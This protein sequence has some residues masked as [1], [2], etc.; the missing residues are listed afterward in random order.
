MLFTKNADRRIWR[1]P[2]LKPGLESSPLCSNNASNFFALGVLLLL[3]WL[4]C[5]LSTFGD[6]GLAPN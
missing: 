4:V 2:L 3:D 6:G 5:A 1:H